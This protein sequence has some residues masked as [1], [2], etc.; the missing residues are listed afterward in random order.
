VR[1]KAIAMGLTIHSPAAAPRPIDRMSKSERWA[2]RIGPFMWTLKPR[3]L[4]RLVIKVEA[5]VTQVKVQP[6]GGSVVDRA[7][8]LPVAVRT[9]PKTADIAIGG[10]APAVGEIVMVASAISAASGYRPVATN[11]SAP[12][13]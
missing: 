2:A 13:R 4:A 12:P 1:V 11:S 5:A 7:D 6:R 3:S 8:Q 10:Q 9:D